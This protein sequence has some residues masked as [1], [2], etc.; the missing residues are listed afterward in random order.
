MSDQTLLPCPHCSGEVKMITAPK[1]GVPSGDDGYESTITCWECHCT[2]RF[3]ALKKAWV[4]ETIIA[5]WNRRE[6]GE[7]T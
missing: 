5:A 1:I 3:W 7:E 2:M 6:K 4:T